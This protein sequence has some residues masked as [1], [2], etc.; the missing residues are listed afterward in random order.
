MFDKISSFWRAIVGPAK[1]VE[2]SKDASAQ[3][4]NTPTY[5]LIAENLDDKNFEVFEAAVYHLCTIADIKTDYRAD[6]LRL[7][8]AYA[9]KHSTPKDRLAYIEKMIKEKNLA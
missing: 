1:S 4:Q 6:I 9:K 5:L 3:K 2:L 7:L 8:E